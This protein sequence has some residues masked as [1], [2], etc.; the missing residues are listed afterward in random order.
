MVERFHRR[1]KEA[2]RAQPHPTSWADA[3]PIVLLNIR[4]TVKEDLQLTPAELVYGEDLRLP[5]QYTP[6]L[7]THSELAFMPALRQ[8]MRAFTPQPPKPPAASATYHHPTLMSADNVFLRVDARTG[9][10]APRYTGP[11][12]VLARAAKHVTLKIGSRHSTVS[13]DRVK[14]AHVDASAQAPLTPLPAIQDL[15]RPQPP[16]QDTQESGTLPAALSPHQEHFHIPSG[17]G[18]FNPEGTVLQSGR[19]VRRPQRYQVNTVSPSSWGA[20]T[21]YGVTGT[22]FLPVCAPSPCIVFPVTSPRLDITS[23]RFTG[24]GG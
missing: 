9:S 19:V 3:L 20:D 18:V 11:H 8:A 10:L 2:L 24:E 5:S 21:W 4:S 13:W 6:A 12:Q 7:N 15:P 23:P 16:T 22:L 14:P 17:E 1:L